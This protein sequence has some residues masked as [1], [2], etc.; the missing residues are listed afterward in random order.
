M[1]IKLTMKDGWVRYIH[2]HTTMFESLLSRE[3]NNEIDELEKRNR[4][5]KAKRMKTKKSIERKG[6]RAK[7]K[8]KRKIQ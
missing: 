4:R 2:I 8:T 3:R 7:R 5:K 1:D 6:R